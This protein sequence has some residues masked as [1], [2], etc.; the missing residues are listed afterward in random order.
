M[1]ISIIFLFIEIN[2]WPHGLEN[3][4][5]T[6]FTVNYF[7]VLPH[8]RHSCHFGQKSYVIFSVLC[9]QQRNL[10]YVTY[11]FFFIFLVIF[12]WNIYKLPLNW[13]KYWNILRPRRCHLSIF[14]YLFCCELLIKNQQK[15]LQE[16]KHLPNFQMT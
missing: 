6:N 11:L 15:Q 14:E 12:V 8:F 7:K 3:T 5:S 4:Y 16:A 2:S 1:F 10:T 13:K 9:Q